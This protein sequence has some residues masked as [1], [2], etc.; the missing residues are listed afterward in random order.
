MQ[1]STFDFGHIRRCTLDLIKQN[2]SSVHFGKKP[3]CAKVDILIKYFL[4]KGLIPH[5]PLIY[6]II[7]INMHIWSHI[8]SP[9]FHHCLGKTILLKKK[10]K[11]S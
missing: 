9:P 11:L 7:G 8:K 2:L 1:S 3:F 4:E 5:L 6:Q 10:Q